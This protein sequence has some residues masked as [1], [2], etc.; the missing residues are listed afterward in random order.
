ML[1]CFFTE[2]FGVGKPPLEVGGWLSSGKPRR[3]ETQP[4]TT[5]SRIADKFTN[6]GHGHYETTGISEKI[7]RKFWKWME[8]RTYYMY[9]I[10]LTLLGRCSFIQYI[11]IFSKTFS[12][13]LMAV[14]SCL[15]HGFYLGKRKNFYYFFL[16]SFSPIKI[17]NILRIKYLTDIFAWK[18]IYLCRYWPF[19]FSKCV[20]YWL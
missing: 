10:Y 2:H 11:W 1:F 9:D 16:R 5:R 19:L 3:R 17:S 20:Y 14:P 18:N 6:L 7:R 12:Y 8:K 15:I 13:V 4:H